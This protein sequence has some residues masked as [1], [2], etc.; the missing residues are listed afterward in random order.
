MFPVTFG[1]KAGLFFEELDKIIH[2]LDAT[3]RSDFLYRFVCQL[4][5]TDAVIDA[6]LIYEFRQGAAILPVK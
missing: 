2:I 4:Q 6:L 5:Q 1:S 3:F